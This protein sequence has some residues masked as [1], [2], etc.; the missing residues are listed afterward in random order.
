MTT[1]KGD[2]RKLTTITGPQAQALRLVMD[3][4]LIFRAKKVREGKM[5]MEV[6]VDAKDW[7][8]T[9]NNNEGRTTKK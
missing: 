2:T 8:F 9:N 6:Y 5:V 7:P 1:T 3:K 4:F